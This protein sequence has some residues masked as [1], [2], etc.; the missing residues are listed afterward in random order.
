MIVLRLFPLTL[1]LLE[2][3]QTR[4]CWLMIYASKTIKVPRI[5]FVMRTFRRLMITLRTFIRITP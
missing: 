5:S 3:T 1:M 2:V 4:V